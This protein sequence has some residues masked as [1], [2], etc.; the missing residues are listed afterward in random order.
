MRRNRTDDLSLHHVRTWPHTVGR[1]QTRKRALTRSQLSGTSILNFLVSR[2]LRSKCLLFKLPSLWSSVTA[3]QL[4]NTGS[5]Q[6]IRK[7]SLLSWSVSSNQSQWSRHNRSG[8]KIVIFLKD[9]ETTGPPRISRPSALPHPHQQLFPSSSKPWCIFVQGCLSLGLLSAQP[10][11]SLSL[12]LIL[13][14]G[15][16][17]LFP[18]YTSGTRTSARLQLRTSQPGNH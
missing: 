8:K 6:Y 13:T 7:C 18:V 1:L 17:L 5:W 4:E 16:L 14:L 11:I 3:A 10:F 9:P 15:G 2:T 12:T